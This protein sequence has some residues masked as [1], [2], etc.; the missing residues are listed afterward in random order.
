MVLT[1]KLW[2]RVNNCFRVMSFAFCTIQYV[3]V[4]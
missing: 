3:N 4:R 1:I 2:F